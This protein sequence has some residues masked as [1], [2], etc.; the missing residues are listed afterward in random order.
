MSG[1]VRPCIS[2]RARARRRAR[3]AAPV[4][5]VPEH[6]PTPEQACISRPQD[7]VS[8]CS[9]NVAAH[10]A[11]APQ[12]TGASKAEA[13]SPVRS[14]SARASGRPELMPRGLGR[15][16]G[17]WRRRSAQVR[18]RVRDHG[19]PCAVCGM[20]IDLTIPANHPRAFSVDHIEPIGMGMNGSPLDIGNLRPAHHGCNSARGNRMRKRARATRPNG[21]APTHVSRD[22]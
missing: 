9:R 14:P 10:P 21:D 18:A 12:P 19:E 17:R 2:T 5:H 15:A 8:R 13:A 1:Q 6:P 3:C 4:P 22:W 7:G 16:G 20:D 11:R